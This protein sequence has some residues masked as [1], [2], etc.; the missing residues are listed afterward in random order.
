MTVLAGLRS[1]DILNRTGVIWFLSDVEDMD[2]A[3]RSFV[4]AASW[5]DWWTFAV[6][7]LALQ[8]SSDSR[9]CLAGGRCQL[10]VAKT[11]SFLW[12]NIILQQ[13]GAVMVK[14][15]K[16]VCFESF[17]DLRNVW[18]SFTDLFP[19]DVL[20]IPV[21]RSSKVLHNEAIRKAFA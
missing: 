18:L 17:M 12:A 1:F 15:K 13:F 7:S 4:E 6:K 16:T 10:L 3:I 9:L 20:E 14:M 21:E 19:A 11:T 5:T 2:S 8:S